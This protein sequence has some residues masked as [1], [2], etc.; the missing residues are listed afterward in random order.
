MISSHLKHV[1]VRS[2]EEC[3]SELKFEIQIS[4]TESSL[5]SRVCANYFRKKISFGQER[6]QS[7]F[8]NLHKLL[9]I[10]L[11]IKIQHSFIEKIEE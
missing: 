9:G 7:L 8:K 11:M 5:N 1:L 4:I 3:F 2:S 10:A 6:E